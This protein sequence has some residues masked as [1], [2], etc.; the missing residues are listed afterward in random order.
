MLKI[1][2][3]TNLSFLLAA[4]AI[5]PLAPTVAIFTAVL[6]LCSGIHHYFENDFTRKLDYV[7]MYWAILALITIGVPWNLSFVFLAGL[8]FVL[9]FGANRTIIGF[10]ILLT[11]ISI[12]VRG[13][14]PSLLHVATIA[15]FSF[16][17]NYLGDNL[18]DEFHEITHGISWHIPIS[19]VIYLSAFY[20]Y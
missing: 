2:V 7:G 15:S 12:G 1:D 14:L 9:L 8:V 3:I 19:Y 4:V 13:D 16:G 11:L 6:G 17:F 18:E 20:I 10:L 5:Y